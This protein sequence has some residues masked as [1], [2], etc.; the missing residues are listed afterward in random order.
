MKIRSKI[1]KLSAI[2]GAL[3]AAGGA[4]ASGFQLM[5]QNASGL[6]NAY[7]G[8]AAAAENASTIYFN[9]A[10]MTRLPG[11][12]VSGALHLIRPSAEFQNA[13]TSA[14]PLGFASPGGSGGDAGDWTG[15]PNGY[16]SWQL[17][18]QLW[19]GVG[20]SVPFG[21]KTEYGEGWVGR[22]QGRLAEIKTLDV[23]PSIAWKLSDAVSL[24]AGLSVQYG[25]VKVRRSAAIPPALGGPAEGRSNLDADD[26]S[27]GYNLGALFT[28]GAAT[29]IGV[30]YR[31]SIEYDLTGSAIVTGIPGLG[32]AGNAVTLNAK[33]PDT[34]SWAI[35]HQLD[36]RWEL[37]GDVTVTRWSK[38]KNIPV[39]ATSASVLGGVGA[40]LDAFDFQFRDTYRIGVGA[41]YQWNSD[42]TLK[43][44]V[45][46]DKSPVEDVWR[47]VTLPDND[48]TW[49][50]IGGKYRMSK[51]A[52]LDF[53]YAYLHIKDPPISQLRGL[54]AAPLRG[55]VVGS[56][57]SNVNIVSAQFTYAF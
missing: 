33:L 43:L 7:A 5:E 18:P 42:F 38:I 31:S 51:Q 50:A 56:Y 32:T 15:I 14:A 37:L 6:G 36:P 12:Q 52:T 11:R 8:Q 21:L 48:R 3:L 26:V 17:N 49:F 46:Y 16:L 13:G 53:G 30:T 24:G 57:D 1:I 40:T 25:Q 4:Q 44:G 29:R 20:L 27:W 34:F 47:T 2:A 10:G 9:P 35:A 41:N 39:I 55:N 54:A 28:L 19:L 45:A 22:F 23:N